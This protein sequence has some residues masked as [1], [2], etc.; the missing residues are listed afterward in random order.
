MVARRTRIPPSSAIILYKNP[1]FKERTQPRD[2]FD[3]NLEPRKIRHPY[4]EMRG[5]CPR[6]ASGRAEWCEFT[7]MYDMTFT[8]GCVAHRFLEFPA[9]STLDGLGRLATLLTAR[10]WPPSLTQ[11]EQRDPSA[12]KCWPTISVSRGSLPLLSTPPSCTLYPQWIERHVTGHNDISSLP[13]HL[14]PIIKQN[15][16]RGKRQAS[17]GLGCAVPLL[18]HNL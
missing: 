14:G 13:V 8:T 7:D 16:E 1:G 11:L 15:N 6:R 5:S 4:P 2:F 18:L 10:A 3:C 12:W 9:V 17:D